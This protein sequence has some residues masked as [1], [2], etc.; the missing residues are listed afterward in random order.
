MRKYRK[1]IAYAA[2]AV[3]ILLGP[4]VLGFTTVELDPELITQV[5]VAVL[6]GAGVFQ[7]ANDP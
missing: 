3:S 2:G 7:V 6:T 5:V 4:A 1:L